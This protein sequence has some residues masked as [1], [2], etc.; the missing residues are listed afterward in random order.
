[1]QT[2]RRFKILENIGEGF[3]NRNEIFEEYFNKRKIFYPIRDKFFENVEYN[4][5]VGLPLIDFDKQYNLI[6][7][8]KIVEIEPINIEDSVYFKTYLNYWKNE[9]QI[10]YD[11]KLALQEAFLEKNNKINEEIDLLEQLIDTDYEIN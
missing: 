8:N 9:L 7:K 5:T 10:L 11:N 1:M 6:F 3:A 2:I 4:N